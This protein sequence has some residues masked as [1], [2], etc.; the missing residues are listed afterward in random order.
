MKTPDTLKPSSPLNIDPDELS[1]S[2]PIFTPNISAISLDVQLSIL[3]KLLTTGSKLLKYP[4]NSIKKPNERLVKVEFYPLVLLYQKNNAFASIGFHT[5][6]EI[7]VGQNTQGFQ[8]W[9]EAMLE[10]RAFSVIYLSNS[11]HKELNFVAPTNELCIQWV[12]G[13]HVLLT[14]RDSNSIHEFVGLPEW[15]M[16]MWKSVD[17]DGNGLK[18]DQITTLMKKLNFRLSQSELKSAFKQSNLTQVDT[19]QFDQFERLYRNLRFRPEIAELFASVCNESMSSI[20]FTE[21]QAFVHEVQKEDWDLEKCQAVFTKFTT[22]NNMDINH[23]TAFLLSS[24]NKLIKK[25]IRD[26]TR[27]LNEYFIN[28]SHNTYLVGDQIVG[29]SSVEG[30]IRALQK[31]CRC[32]EIDCWDGP[33][34]EPVIYHGHTLTSKIT[35]LDA[36]KSIKKYAFMVSD[37]PLILSLEVHCCAMQQNRMASILVD[38]LG[39]ELLVDVIVGV[40]IGVLPTPAQLLKKI[41]I[42]AKIYDDDDLDFEDDSPSI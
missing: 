9:R 5:I 17:V 11:K 28:S 34:G 31:G 37:C 12:T 23:F 22:Q 4:K 35:F 19:L 33:N 1:P 3:E 15:L 42:K 10:E 30:Y 7:R 29:D 40:P 13:L 8:V 32:V 39:D 6:V 26:L 27:P 38:I 21:F 20:R 18:L 24:R 25:E 36:I 2:K 41:L 16:D 14:N